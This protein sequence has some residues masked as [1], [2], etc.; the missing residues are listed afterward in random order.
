MT[1]QSAI[2]IH[3]V[4]VVDEGDLLRVITQP[5]HAR[6]AAELLSLWRADGLSDHP[7]R[8]QLLFA[9]KE[10]DNGW[11]EADAAPWIDPATQRIYD[12]TSFPDSGRLEIWK[13]GILRFADQQPYSALLIAEHA[14]LIHRPLSDDWQD[15]FDQ[16]EPLRI[17]WLDRAAA[18]HPEIQADYRHLELA[19][20][21][22]LAYC[23]RRTGPWKGRSATAL[24]AGDVLHL[25]PFPLAGATTF[26]IP[27]RR[28]LNQPY[29][30]DS[31]A[32]SALARA[33][34]DHLAVKVAPF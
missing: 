13:R 18:N 11:R 19:D 20:A 8:E 29:S 26:Q 9:V 5:D 27:V 15:L 21:L 23:T 1:L 7:R 16:I 6:F 34:W 33:R 4:I 10:H 2:L 28:I 32:G 25:E 12:F 31:Q 14:E 22:S 24:V 3:A 17:E 30:T